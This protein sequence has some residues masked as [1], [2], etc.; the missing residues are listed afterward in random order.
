MSIWQKSQ[1]STLKLH[2][3][4]VDSQISGEMLGHEDVID[5]IIIWP[6]FTL[7]QIFN[8]PNPLGLYL[9]VLT[10]PYKHIN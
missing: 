7:H 8:S 2:N 4:R 3:Y 9:L 1:S 6:D 10:S 5:N